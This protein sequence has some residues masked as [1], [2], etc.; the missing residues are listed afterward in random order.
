MWLTIK[1]PP[2]PLREAIEGFT[3]KMEHFGVSHHVYELVE[4]N[5]VLLANLLTAAM[6][7]EKA[8]E[9]YEEFK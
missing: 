8:N 5:R 2:G 9:F 4:I 6:R 3:P 1:L 7:H